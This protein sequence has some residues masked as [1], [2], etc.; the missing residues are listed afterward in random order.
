[1]S[2]LANPASDMRPVTLDT[3]MSGVR[4]LYIDVAGNLSFTS[5][6]GATRTVPVQA[7]TLPLRVK[8]VN[9]SGTTATG[10][11]AFY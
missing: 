2:T 10:I 1:M 3:E 4:G 9:T 6:S 11:S 8:R 5:L 7:G